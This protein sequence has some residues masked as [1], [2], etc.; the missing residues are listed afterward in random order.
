MNKTE[1]LKTNLIV[2]GA[3]LFN[4]IFW[5]EK[6]GLNTAL[7]DVF[8]VACVFYLY[9]GFIKN[10]T[11]RLLAAG[12]FITI[13]MV[14]L[15]NTILSKIA[16]TI[17]LLLLVTFAQY[18]HRSA[19]YAAGSVIL[20]YI[21][22]VPGFV[23]QVRSIMGNPG[24]LKG[25]PRIVRMLLIPFALVAV[26]FAI[27]AF[28]N[29]VFSNIATDVATAVQDWFSNVFDWFSVPRFGFF[30]LGMFI[31]AGL[32]LKTKSNYFSKADINQ[33]DLLARKRRRF[34]KWRAGSFAGLL[35][36]IMGKA[37]TGLLAI[38]TEYKTGLISLLLLNVLLLFINILDIKYVWFGFTFSDDV[39][40]SAYVHE[41]AGLLIFSIILAM[42]ILLFF[43]R[44]NLNFYKKNK[45]LQYGA[46]LWIFQNIILVISVFIRD[47]Y[48]ISH[49]GLA[50]KRIGL[51]FF[52][53]MVVCGLITV[54]C[55]I[56]Y[57][58]TAYYILRI[59]AW[60]GI[61]L[62]VLATTVHWDYRIAKYNL[63]RKSLV[64]LDIPYLLSLSDRTL[65]LIEKNK[66]VLTHDTHQ[67][68]THYKPYTSYNAAGYFE[69]RKKI[70][71]EK[72]KQYSWLSWNSADA[73]VRKSLA[74]TTII[75]KN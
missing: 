33:T 9:P 24:S 12:H 65:P 54:F 71:I 73:L 10:S 53:A 28:A 60:A 62:L 18:A 69:E 61:F 75:S 70:F 44:G 34:G 39:N 4:I 2:T 50:Y 23:V 49:F 58:R 25:L 66:D 68:H 56:L 59:N 48:Y 19:W 37:S 11:T 45:W 46:Y 16:C 41:G 26:F 15:H 21:F 14:L 29:T 35:A 8:I 72:Q 20:K 42:L 52:L 55:K 17:T 43:F 57:T 1:T 3:I 67:W 36:V 74:S 5:Q 63:E 6:M 30:L 31:V 13:A 64:P 38:K 7:F 40:L 22:A 27:Y 32:I 51:L 47:F